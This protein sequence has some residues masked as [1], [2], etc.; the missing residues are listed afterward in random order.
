[1]MGIMPNNVGGFGDVEKASKVFVRNELAPLQG[2]IKELN[3][4]IGKEV[5]K[6]NNYN[7]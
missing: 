3:E 7:L 4:W 6:F 1:M 5:I 2:R